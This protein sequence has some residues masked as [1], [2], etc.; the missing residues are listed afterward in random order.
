MNRSKIF[1]SDNS[2]SFVLGKRKLRTSEERER[3]GIGCGRPRKL[4]AHAASYL[5]S[6][7]S[8]VV[9]LFHACAVHCLT[10]FLCSTHLVRQNELA[11]FFSRFAVDGT[12]VK[13]RSCLQRG[14]PKPRRLQIKVTGTASFGAGGRR[15]P[16]SRIKGRSLAFCPGSHC[17]SDCFAVCSSDGWRGVWR[18]EGCL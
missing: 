5:S 3:A 1:C 12:N 4:Q 2:A 10:R 13:A 7:T 17:E 8:A 14:Q 11:L 16:S 18:S 9:G 15:T 6:C